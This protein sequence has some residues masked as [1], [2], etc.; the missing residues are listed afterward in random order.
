M[1]S[2]LDDRTQISTLDTTDML[3]DMA[4]YPEDARQAIA[5][6]EKVSLASLTDRA[7][8]SILFLGMG[9]SAIGG[10]LIADWLFHSSRI[11]ININRGYNLPGFVTER[12]LVLAVSY[13]GNTEETLSAFHRAIDVGCPLIAITSGG[14]LEPLARDRGIPCVK[15]PEG[16]QPRAAIA[17]QFFIPATILM[18]LGLTEGRWREVDEALEVLEGLRDLYGSGSLVGVNPAKELALS[19]GGLIPFVY[20]PRLFDGVTYRWS[21]QFNENSKSPAGHGV[22][23]ELFHNVIVGMEASNPFLEPLCLV[24]IRD[25]EGEGD[26]NGKIDRFISIIE[27]NVNGL[28]QVEAKGRGLLARMFS[29][30]YLGDYAS[31]YL[32]ILRGH[33]PSTTESIDQLK[34]GS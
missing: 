14:K 19:L 4:K 27:P 29:V 7:F 10:K 6:A 26:L 15:M 17:W 9:G 25:P 2:R 33:D 28:L 21:T 11:P 8:D 22:F 23:P 34:R 24:I 5:A 13:S 30:I 31:V 20:G 3:G 16:K 32:G 1:T 12:T 18:R